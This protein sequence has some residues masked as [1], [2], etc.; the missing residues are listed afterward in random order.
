MSAFEPTQIALPMYDNIP[1]KDFLLF[2]L[3]EIE[4]LYY[5]LHYHNWVALDDMYI[6]PRTQAAPCP[7][8]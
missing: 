1:N 5:Q 8:N 7:L 2:R 3:L 4:N 6:A